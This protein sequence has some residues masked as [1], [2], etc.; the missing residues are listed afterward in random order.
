ME[1]LDPHRKEPVLSKGGRVKGVPAA[2]DVLKEEGVAAAEN[3]KKLI[4]IR[5]VHLSTVN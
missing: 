3:R 4:L 5:Q 1:P 2:K